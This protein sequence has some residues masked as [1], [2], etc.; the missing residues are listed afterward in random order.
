M[1]QHLGL[2]KLMPIKR[3]RKH[4]RKQR[5][6]CHYFISVSFFVIF[7]QFFIFRLFSLNALCVA[8][9]FRIRIFFF[10]FSFSPPSLY[11]N[12]YLIGLIIR[13]REFYFHFWFVYNFD[14]SF[15]FSFQFIFSIELFRP[16]MGCLGEKLVFDLVCLCF[17]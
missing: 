8:S 6:L 1:K 2:V 16:F 14:F 15:S 5:N 13:S 11:V 17:D 12:F 9:I 7:A 4:F 3:K 10:V